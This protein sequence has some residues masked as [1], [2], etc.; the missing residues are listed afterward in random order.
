M[1]T[2]EPDTK[3]QFSELGITIWKHRLPPVR[4]PREARDGSLHLVRSA[5]SSSSSSGSIKSSTVHA[6]AMQEGSLI[7]SGTYHGIQQA[8]SKPH[9]NHALVGLPV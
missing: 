5:S 7:I 8:I 2:D 4:V 9:A 3:Q 6:L 1:S